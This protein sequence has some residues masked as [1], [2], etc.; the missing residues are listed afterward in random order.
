MIETFVFIAF[1]V[2]EIVID[3]RIT[4]DCLVILTDDVLAEGTK[5][6]TLNGYRY[7]AYTGI[8]Y[9]TPPVGS[10]RFE[11]PKKI[12]FWRGRK[13]FI[14]DANICVQMSYETFQVIGNEDCLYLNIFTLKSRQTEKNNEN[15]DNLMPVLFFI[16]GGSF[17]IGSSNSNLNMPD[18]ILEKEIVI[19]TINYRLGPFGFLSFDNVTRNVGLHDQRMALE[20]IYE[21]ILYFGGNKNGITL[22]GWSSGAASVSYHMYANKSKDLFDKAILMSGN[23]LNPWAFESDV[24]KCSCELLSKLNIKNS[25]FAIDELKAFDAY[26]L[27]PPIFTDELKI[28]FFG[29]EQFCFVPTL[30]NDFVPQPPHVNIRHQNPSNVPLLIGTT[31][32]ESDWVMSFEFTNDKYP[33]KN[34]NISSDLNKVMARYFDKHYDSIE[35]DRFIRNFQHASDMS[36][37]I[38]QFIQQYVDSTKQGNIFVYRFAFDGQFSDLKDYAGAVHGDE[39]EFLFKKNSVEVNRN[40][41][42]MEQILEQ[43]MISMWSNFIQFGNPTPND[44]ADDFLFHITWPPFSID[45]R[46]LLNIDY[47]MTVERLSDNDG[48]FKFWDCIY[49]CMYYFEC[50]ELNEYLLYSK[51]IEF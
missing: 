39:L 10:N 4:S 38:Y 17:N 33:N 15:T 8:P 20:W 23:M 50:D 22:S 29:S 34:P 41:I 35:M 32:L 13:R 24:D 26:D 45:K 27:I 12:P 48:A 6:A 3:F 5:R 47:D 30:D 51:T 7:C 44:R 21:N 25:P 42:N 9:A 36:Y 1:V 19:V 18:Y 37:G 11:L 14:E 31:S 40:N 43:R 2:I 49:Q 46:L 28:D 16:H